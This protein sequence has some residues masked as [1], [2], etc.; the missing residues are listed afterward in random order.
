MKTTSVTTPLMERTICPKCQHFHRHIIAAKC[1]CCGEDCKA[2][3][4]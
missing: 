2:A 4:S 1:E 3:N